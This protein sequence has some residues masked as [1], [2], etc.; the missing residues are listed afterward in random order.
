MKKYHVKKEYKHDYAGLDKKVYR[1]LHSIFYK[2]C[3]SNEKAYPFYASY[4][5]RKKVPGNPER[6]YKHY[7]TEEPVYLA[8]FGHGLG[9]WRTALMSAR[10]FGLE[11]AYT[12]M[13]SEEWEKT[14]DLGYGIDKAEDLINRGYKKVRLPYYDMNKEESCDLIRE[15]IDSYKGTDVVFYNEYQQ[16]TAKGDDQKCDEMIREMFWNTP[17]RKEDKL[18]YDDAYTNVAIHIRRGDVSQLLS[19][20]DESMRVR[21]LELSYY[22][23]IIET[24]LTSL[25][26]RKIRFYI[27]SEGEEKAFSELK[28]TSADLVFCLDMSAPDSFLHLCRSDILLTAPSGFS[29]I[30]GAVNK[31]LKITPEGNFLVAPKK[32]DWIFAD[33]TGHLTEGSVE[34]IK[35]LG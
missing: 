33:K 22:K 28:E 21:W 4:R 1:K 17:K 23:N 9:G 6:E 32:A 7:I 29:M 14:L 30:A 35:D 18:I 24:L 34:R 5:H 20:G 8:G 11:Y 31:G 16:W 26:D 27:F 12:P 25:H 10:V 19:Q 13:V 15:I 3:G 2:I